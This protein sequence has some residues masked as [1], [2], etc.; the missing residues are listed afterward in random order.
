[1]TVKKPFR[2]ALIP[3]DASRWSMQ[4]AEYG[5]RLAEALGFA[6]I[7]LYVVDTDN[8]K[9]LASFLKKEAREVEE[10]FR[11]EGESALAHME[12]LAR[13][14]GVEFRGVIA[15]GVP[16]RIIVDLARS[17]GVD[18]III[19]KVGHRGPRRILIGPVT[20]RV[21]EDA[22]CPILVVPQS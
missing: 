2:K 15:Q 21:L 10:S 19:G 14:G 12:G 20:E 16:H 3:V 5:I 8:A 4:A 11:R 22:P 6:V 1:M 18:L 7:G 13:K 9:L 17:E